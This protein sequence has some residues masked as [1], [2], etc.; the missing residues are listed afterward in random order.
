MNL[1]EKNM[2]CKSIIFIFSAY[3]KSVQFLYDCFPFQSK[4]NIWYYSTLF[5]LN[6]NTVATF[7]NS[8]N[9]VSLEPSFSFQ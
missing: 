6:L 1:G 9:H 7:P 3:Y 5:K 2:F 8:W 4:A